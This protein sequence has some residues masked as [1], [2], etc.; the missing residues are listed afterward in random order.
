MR[1]FSY[2]CLMGKTKNKI[3]H[4]AIELWSRDKNATLDDISQHIGISRRT[5]HRQYNGRDDLKLSVLNHLVNEYLKSV[6]EKLTE[7]SET[8]IE[9][10]KKLFYNDIRNA[11]NYIVY[12]NLQEET[13]S[14]SLE[15][16][17][18]IQKL[19]HIYKSIFSELVQTGLVNNLVTE[20]W[21]EVFYASVVEATIKAL[22]NGGEMED[23]MF[24][25]WK[26]FWNGI[27]K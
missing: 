18:D 23:L 19:H 22:R 3:L 13:Y 12:R 24:I 11:D 20:A 27:K 1:H 21:I 15:N 7:P 5:L 25:G 8:P 26:S 16:D 10:L 17:A 4:A 6:E 14:A 9:K 2:I